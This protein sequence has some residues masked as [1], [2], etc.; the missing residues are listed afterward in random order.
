MSLSNRWQVELQRLKDEARYRTLQPPAG[1]DFSSNDYLGYS[2]CPS[3][4]S[5]LSRGGTAS[6]LLRGQHPI[7]DEV[8][9]KLAEWHHA[10]VALMFTSGYAANEGLLSTV[11]AAGDTVFSDQHNHASII[12][13]VR[14]GRAEKVVFSHGD[15]NELEAVMRQRRPARAAQQAW[16]IVTE[17]LFGMEGDRASLQAL[18]ELAERYQAHLIVDEAHA[19]GCF[20]PGGS[21]LVDALG[22]RERVLATVHT[23]GKALAVPGAYIAGTRLLRELLVNRCRHF[24]FTTALPP[25]IGAWWLDT[26][27]AVVVDESAR[28][29]LHERVRVFRQQA[30]LRRIP[31]GGTD[32]LATV[33]LG[34]DAAAV[35]AA[36]RLQQAGFDIRAIRP[37]TVPPGTAR[38]RISIHADHDPAVLLDLA[39]LL[40]TLV[41][42][43]S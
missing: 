10:E 37:P 22:L 1:I 34:T 29:A 9:A 5:D 41:S 11:L 32:Y 15:V 27:K 28:V 3:P 18:A 8:E 13:G 39:N 4:V 26:L 6:R 7:W 20:G 17:S 31:V 19:T 12:D 14:L 40:A 36:R 33:I 43:T 30:S 21:G 23:G 35:E 24:I 25:Q 38:L 2:K 16:F 42:P